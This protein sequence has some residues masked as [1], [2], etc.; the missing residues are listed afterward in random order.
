MRAHDLIDRREIVVLNVTA[1]FPEM[2]R[3]TVGTRLLH[4]NDR[5]R[6]A[7]V[8]RASGLPQRSNV[9]DIYAE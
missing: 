1:I 3:N 8:A 6:G 5:V 4:H 7:W 9:V 2:H